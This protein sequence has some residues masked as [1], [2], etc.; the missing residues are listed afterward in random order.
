MSHV[1]GRDYCPYCNG[2]NLKTAR[3][4]ELGTTFTKVRSMDCEE[5]WP[6]PS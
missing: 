5:S 6:M 2:E 1:R 3:L 4:I